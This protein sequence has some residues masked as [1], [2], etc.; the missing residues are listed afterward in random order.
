LT[1]GKDRKASIVLADRGHIRVRR[2]CEDLRADVG[3]M[4]R[5]LRE[6]EKRLVYNLSYILAPQTF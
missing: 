4:T 5:R 3:A 2:D 1:I 6:N